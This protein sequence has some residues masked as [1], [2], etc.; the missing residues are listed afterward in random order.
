[1]DFLEIDISLVDIGMDELHPEP[2]AYI[3]TFMPIDQSTF[4]GRMKDAY[5]CPFV[6]STRTHGIKLF[7]DS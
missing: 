5:P 7:S 2:V 1:M 3:N 4:N 6:G